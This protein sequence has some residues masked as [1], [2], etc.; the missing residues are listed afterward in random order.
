MSINIIHIINGTKWKFNLY[1]D[2]NWRRGPQSQKTD[3]YSTLLEADN[4]SGKRQ[5][6]SVP[7]LLSRDGL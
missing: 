4:I 6:Q 2:L 7:K 3:N 1:L 5:D